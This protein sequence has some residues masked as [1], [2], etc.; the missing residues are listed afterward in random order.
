MFK[1]LRAENAADN[2]RLYG[3][4]LM[5]QQVHHP[6][7]DHTHRRPFYHHVVGARLRNSATQGPRNECSLVQL[8]IPGC[9]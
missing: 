1:M 6:L 5:L 9:N 3:V 4:T 7:H 2:L 8:M